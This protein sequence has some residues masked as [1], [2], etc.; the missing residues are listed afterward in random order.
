ML[1]PRDLS[2]FITGGFQVLRSV[3]LPTAEATC[4]QAAIVALWWS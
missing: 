3:A 4:F 1:P 2:K